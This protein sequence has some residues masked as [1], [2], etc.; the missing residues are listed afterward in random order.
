MRARRNIPTVGVRHQGQRAFTL[1]EVILAIGIVVS[2]LIVA[3]LFYRQAA[4]LRNQILAE[5]E[6][7]STI[8]LLLDRLAADLREAMPNAESGYDF[9]GDPGSL[10]FVRPSLARP[11]TGAAGAAAFPGL[12]RVTYAA[13]LGNEGTNRAVIGFDRTEGPPRLLRPALS[14]ADSTNT[15]LTRVVVPAALDLAITNNPVE[16][17]TELIHYVRFRYWDGAAWV[18][19]WTNAAPPPGVEIILATDP[20]PETGIEPLESDTEVANAGEYP[21]GALRR[22]VFLPVGKRV[23]KPEAVADELLSPP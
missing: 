11:R 8:R 14:L 9:L 17:L 2:L 1:V 16:P 15:S 13:V 7:C 19:S 10:S 4:D 20:A 6:R 23:R 3:L 22:V 12:M 5:S 21:L 18:S